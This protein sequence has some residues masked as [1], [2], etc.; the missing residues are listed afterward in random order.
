MALKGAGK[1]PD[2]PEFS[3]TKLLLTVQSLEDELIAAKQSAKKAAS[4]RDVARSQVND[5]KE[6][7][8]ACK[9]ELHKKVSGLQKDLQHWT[10]RVCAARYTCLYK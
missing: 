5:L 10:A 1:V 4:E 2:A 3:F 8:T 9:A 7:L 6:E